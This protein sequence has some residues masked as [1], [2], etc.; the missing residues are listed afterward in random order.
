MISPAREEVEGRE[1]LEDAHGV[2]RAEH[3][4][5]ARQPDPLRPRG[6]RRERQRG[7]RDGE[8]GPVVLADAE[9]V[10]PDLVGELGLVEQVAKTGVRV[11]RLV[12]QVGEGVDAELHQAATGCR[13]RFAFARTAPKIPSAEPTG[14]AAGSRRCVGRR[15]RPCSNRREAARERAG[16]RLPARSPDRRDLC[17]PHRGARRAPTGAPSR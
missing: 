1:L 3:G 2:V 16:P 12:P 15:T 4:D 8:I 14:S 5:G 6:D 13:R 10:E 7:R 9:D 17:R 11:D